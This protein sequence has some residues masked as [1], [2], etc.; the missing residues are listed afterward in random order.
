MLVILS[1]F[2]TTQ[3]IERADKERLKI[4]GVIKSGRRRLDRLLAIRGRG[5]KDAE[6]TIDIAPRNCLL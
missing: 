4:P 3:A 2:T 5:N 6:I 1:S